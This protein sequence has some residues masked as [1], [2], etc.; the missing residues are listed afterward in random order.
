MLLKEPVTESNAANDLLL[1]RN[2]GDPGSRSRKPDQ[3]VYVPR[4]ARRS[5]EG[6][7]RTTTAERL[8]K[9]EADKGKHP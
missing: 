9:R 6:P 7:R 1:S 8:L 3:A 4:G 5:E 2:M